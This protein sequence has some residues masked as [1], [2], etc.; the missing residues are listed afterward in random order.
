MQPSTIRLQAFCRRE[1]R[2]L[3]AWWFA[4][5]ICVSQTGCESSQ[6]DAQ[7]DTTYP[8][9]VAATTGMVAD[10]VR[11]VGGDNVRVDQLMGAGV[12]PHLYKTS[13]DDVIQ[14][15]SANLVFYSGLM[16]EG[17]MTDVLVQ[18]ARKKPVYAV[19]E[20]IDEQF[21]LVPEDM[22]DHYDPHVWMDVSAWSK[23]VSVVA[24]ALTAYDPPHADEYAERAKAYQTR[25]N[26]L[27]EYGKN[28]IASIPE[29]RRL[30]LTSHDAFNYLGRAYGIEVRGVQ[31]LSTESEAGL[32]QINELVDLIVD[33]KITAVFVESSVSPKNIEALI[34]GAA[35]RSHTVEK[36]G[37]LFSDAF[38]GEG[39]YEGTYEGMLDH[40]LTL[41]TRG[42]GGS[43]PEK[44][45]NGKL[46]NDR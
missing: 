44:G 10:I 17:K 28:C 15:D 1:F 25:L 18:I 13:R 22:V 32:R 34:A 35:S 31:G 14:I 20:E 5:C 41:I 40:N 19:T 42:L 6:T 23:C 46:S 9:T 8:I 33:K 26:A 43:A 30:L 24:T 39:T 2:C 21:L 11:N 3:W 36:G 38:G 45:L 12:D 29:D 7:T 16:L 27:H 4:L 37:E